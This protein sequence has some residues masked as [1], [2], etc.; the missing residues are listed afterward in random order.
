M[1]GP[2]N[3]GASTAKGTIG[4][5]RNLIEWLNMQFCGANMISSTGINPL[6]LLANRNINIF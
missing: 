4:I 1:A 6:I 5:I 3:E 2:K